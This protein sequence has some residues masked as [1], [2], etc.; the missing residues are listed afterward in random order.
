[1]NKKEF[2]DQ[3][4]KKYAKTDEDNVLI[5]VMKDITSYFIEID[6]NLKNID[7]KLVIG[8]NYHVVD[9]IVIELGSNH[10]HFKRLDKSIKITYVS[11]VGNQYSDQYA[12]LDL[13][14]IIIVNGKLVI[15]NSQI[16]FSIN[17]LDHYLN[18]LIV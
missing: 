2:I 18:Y 16:D 15:K 11:N 1:M 14:E 9:L 3:V 4:N 6:N 12:Q 7:E 13:D 5:P 17:Y 8:F 10:I